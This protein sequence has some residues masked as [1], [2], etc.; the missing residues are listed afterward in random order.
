MFDRHDDPRMIAR[1]IFSL[2]IGSSFIAIAIVLFAA[3]RLRPHDHGFATVGV[4]ALMTIYL[5]VGLYLV[6]SLLLRRIPSATTQSFS[7]PD[8]ESDDLWDE[9]LDGI[10]S[11]VIY[12]SAAPTK[13]RR[14]I[15]GAGSV[16]V[17]RGTLGWE[18]QSTP[19]PERRKF[20][21][22]VHKLRAINYPDTDLTL[23]DLGANDLSGADLS[24]ADLSRAD[25]SKARLRWADIRESDLRETVLRGADLVH[26]DFRRSDLSGADF[27]DAIVRE[28]ILRWVDLRGADLTGADLFGA[29]LEE[30]L[31]QGAICRRASLMLASLNGTI[32]DEA[33]LSEADLRG[34]DLRG[35]NLGRA[36]GLTQ[37]QVDSARGDAG[38]ILPWGL[39]RP[40][41]WDKTMNSVRS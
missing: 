7:D 20:H 13:E 25:L 8:L 38:T 32:L 33:G 31:L 41:N 34:T 28:G 9:Q 19:R 24:G 10:V 2:F 21:E 4:T 22:L 30:A 17:A 29:N 6:T 3:L 37:A 12:Q 18:G 15:V 40:G 11:G 27:S 1:R 14:R 39:V 35:A 36:R 16:R 5:T 26:A 23:I